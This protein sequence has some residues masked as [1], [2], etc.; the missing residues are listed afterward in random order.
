MELA[1]LTI[2]VL[3]IVIVCQHIRYTSLLDDLEGSN[4]RNAFL[5]QECEKQLTAL[6]K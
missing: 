5:M 1:I 3:L 6:G 2:V 4:K